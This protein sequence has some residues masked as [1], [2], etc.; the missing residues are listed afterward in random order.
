MANG[1]CRM[2]GGPSTGPRTP[3]GLERSRR[4]NWKHGYYSAEAKQVRR[5]ARRQF[6]LLRQLMAAGNEDDVLDLDPDLDGWR[7]G[8]RWSGGPGRHRNAGRREGQSESGK[9]GYAHIG[10]PVGIAWTRLAGAD[11]LTVFMSA[12]CLPPPSVH[13]LER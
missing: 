1:R 13:G 6:R 8:L 11:Y 2:H 4:S 12:G 9:Q 7:L 5:E 3:E 10:P